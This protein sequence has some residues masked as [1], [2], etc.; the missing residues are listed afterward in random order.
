MKM[1]IGCLLG[2]GAPVI[3]IV[4]VTRSLILDEHVSSIFIGVV[5]W[6]MLVHFAGKAIVIT[7]LER[8]KTQ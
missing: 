2:F 3:G 6:L 4:L 8:R 1:F 5:V 7:Q